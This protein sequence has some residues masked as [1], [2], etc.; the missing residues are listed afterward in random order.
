M[1][2]LVDLVR[3]AVLTTSGIAGPILGIA[4]ITA[5]VVAVVQTVTNLHE[6]TIAVVPRLLVMGTALGCL[7]PWILARLVEYA[8]QL[9]SQAGQVSGWN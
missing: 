6:P 5:M 7:A 8:Q 3:E 4:L 1:N 9:F 2:S